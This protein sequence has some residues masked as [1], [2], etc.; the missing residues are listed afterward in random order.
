MSGRIPDFLLERLRLGELDPVDADRL[1]ARMSSADEARLQALV[2]DEA[3]ILADHPPRVVGAAVRA[4]L[5]GERRP[6]RLWVALPLLAVAAAVAFFAL[7]PVPAERVAAEA[8]E[9]TRA[10]GDDR[11]LVFRRTAEGN[12]LLGDGDRAA[13]GDE[14]QLALS[15]ADSRH[16]AVLSVDGRG[17]VTT[18]YPVGEAAAPVD[19]GRHPLDHAFALDDAPRYERFVLVTADAPIDLDAVRAALE[20]AGDGPLDLPESW[21]QATVTLRKGARGG[22]R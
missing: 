9:I 13:A 17:A 8:P 3:R 18:H 20:E 15:M 12:E 11:L 6:R 7:R 2:D 5:A 14:L 22:E 1:R 19:A 21:Q 10:K 4:R 16:A